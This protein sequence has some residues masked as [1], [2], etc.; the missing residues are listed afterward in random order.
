MIRFH[1][2]F[3]V[4]SAGIVFLAVSSAAH[5]LS[6]ALQVTRCGTEP[7]IDASTFTSIGASG[8][9][10]INGSSCVRIPDW[11]AAVDR[12][13]P[14]AQYYLYFAHHNGNEIRMAWA[15]DIEGPWTLF[16]MG[17]NDDPIGETVDESTM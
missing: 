12:A 10:N 4:I 16:N 2:R 5:G 13:A 8:S 9:D 7:I 15:A 6:P 11:V 1:R 14:G 3:P 17:T